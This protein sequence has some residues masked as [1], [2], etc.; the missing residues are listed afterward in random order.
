MFLNLQHFSSVVLNEL[1]VIRAG[2]HKVLVRIAN[3]GGPGQ[4]ALGVPYLSRPL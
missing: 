1:M 2:I 3:R 4:T